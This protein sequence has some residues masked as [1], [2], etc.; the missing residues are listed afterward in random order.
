MWLLEIG[1]FAGAAVAIM[2]LISKM[3]S[4]I[5]AIQNLIVRLDAMQRDIELGCDEREMIQ[6]KLANQAD[7]LLEVETILPEIREDMSEIKVSVKELV[8]YVFR[9][10]GV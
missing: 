4:L 9:Q 1:G 6:V 8:K 2:T 10:P 5:T 3:V 7:R